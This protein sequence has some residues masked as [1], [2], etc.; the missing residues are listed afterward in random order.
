MLAASA[1]DPEGDA[2]VWAWTQTSGPTVTLA[3]ADT[4]APTFT[5]P[6]VASG[7]TDLV[8]HAVVTANGLTGTGDLTVTV[9]AVNRQP[10]VAGLNDVTENERVQLTLTAS[11][12]DPDQDVLTWK[13]TQTGGP[14]VMLSGDTTEAVQFTTPEVSGDTR[15]AFSV[16]AKD[17]GGASSTAT[18][19]VTVKNVNRAPTAV[20]ASSGNVSGER[21]VL[22]GAG[23]TDADGDALAGNWTQTGGPPV[24]LQ[25]AGEKV[26]TF[27]AP[28]VDAV[29]ELTFQLTVTDGT[30]SAMASTV[31]AVQPAAAKVSGCGCTTGVDALP[32]GLLALALR[33]RSRRRR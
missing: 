24:E 33:L 1:M 3:G 7:T 32:F 27:I 9:R 4:A 25:V 2:L 30:A 5:A 20:A 15:L 8:F 12:L 26:A 10:V 29:T 11:A 16:E 18:V 23:S 17:P 19:Q 22:S 28:K 13:W 21:I 14:V 6:D 31:V